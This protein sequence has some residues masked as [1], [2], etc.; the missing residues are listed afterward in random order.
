MRRR[1]TYLRR[2][3]PVDPYWILVC[4]LLGALL[5]LG[6]MGALMKVGGL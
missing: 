3:Q 1:A 5:A 4:A 2:R 6:M